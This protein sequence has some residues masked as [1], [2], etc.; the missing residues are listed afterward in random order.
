MHLSLTPVQ[1]IEIRQELSLSGGVTTTVFPVSEH[2]LGQSSDH[3]W[4]AR[5]VK[6][7]CKPKSFVSL[8]DYL[9]ACVFPDCYFLVMDFY[10]DEA[11]P[12]REILTQYQC[13]K[14]DEYLQ[15]ALW[16]AY[17]EHCDERE[18]SWCE[19]REKADHIYY[20]SVA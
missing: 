11:P 2:W 18:R 3:Q 20:R 17:Q 14:I 15:V 12:L 1:T 8:M 4:A 5:H 10:A 16:V 7:K 19:V 9:F 6:G 13:A